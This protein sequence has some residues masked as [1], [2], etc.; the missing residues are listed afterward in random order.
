MDGRVSVI[1]VTLLDIPETEILAS[2]IDARIAEIA[3]EEKGREK[4]YL[5]AIRSAPIP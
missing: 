1:A 4:P 5:V 3:D 2:R